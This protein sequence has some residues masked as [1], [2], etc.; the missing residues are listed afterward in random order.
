[1]W[2][3]LL[4]EDKVFVRRKLIQWDLFGYTV[5]GEASNGREA[6]ESMAED[7]PDL[8]I[9]D[10]MMPGM[11]GIKLLRNARSN[12]LISRFVMLNCMNEFKY[13]QQA[14]EYGTSGYI[15]KLSMSMQSMQDILAKV[16]KELT[17]ANEQRQQVLSQKFNVFY[18]QILDRIKADRLEEEAL[19]GEVHG[20]RD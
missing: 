18:K 19:P 17:A 15:L 3:I 6:L 5:S 7:M 10:I 12:E 13:A 16:A 2:K 8:V 20:V 11:D 1:M 14:L 9:T 4:V